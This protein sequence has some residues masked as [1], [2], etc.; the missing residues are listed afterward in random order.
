MLT[1][2]LEF[3]TT[4]ACEKDDFQAI[5]DKDIRTCPT[6]PSSIISQKDISRI[7]KEIRETDLDVFRQIK[8]K[9]VPKLK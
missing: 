3:F 9:R 4:R 5:F 8:V 6:S 7:R 2:L 1:V